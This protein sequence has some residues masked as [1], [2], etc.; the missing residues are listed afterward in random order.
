MTL[1]FLHVFRRVYEQRSFSKAAEILYLTQPTVSAHIKSLE[2]EL[3]IPLFDRLGRETVPTRAGDILYG[4]AKEIERL[5]LEAGE[6]INQFRG[7]MKGHLEIGGSTIPGEYLLPSMMGDFKREYPGITA[8]VRIGDTKKIA[9][10]VVNG[11]VELGFVGGAV[12]DKV[13]QSTLFAMDELVLIAS[14]SFLKKS[15]T[16]EELEAEPLVFREKGSGSRNA[17]EKWMQ[18][19][20]LSIDDFYIA[21]EMGSTEA[22][23]QSVKSGLGLSVIS[24]L[25]VTEELAD[26]RLKEVKLPGLPIKRN[27]YIISHKLRSKSP[28]CMAFIDYLTKDS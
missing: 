11:D 26:G 4:Y 17:L 10:M 22:I 27:L 23:K 21:A 14:P 1:A 20:S 6:V 7:N 28:I 3:D 16:M 24:K 13:L 5:K 15:I 9:E 19:S 2:E 18:K 8:T 12:D 25:A